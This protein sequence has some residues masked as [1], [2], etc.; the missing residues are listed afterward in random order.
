[1]TSKA[2][3][4]GE[5]AIEFKSS[6][7]T[8]FTC[9]SLASAA[10]RQ[11]AQYDFGAQT[12]ARAFKYN[13]RGFVKFATAPVVGETI[14]IYAKTSDGTHIDNDDGTTDAAVSAED[15][16]KNLHYLGSITVDEASTTPEFSASGTVRLT[17][18]YFQVVFWNAAADALSATATDHGFILEPFSI[19][20][21][22]T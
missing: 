14:D 21:Q 17:S 13:W 16:L 3:F 20:G 22:A 19:Q 7:G 18:R 6:G 9:T 4:L 2:Y 1:L 11:S 15:K 8:G 5:T 12:T 10:G